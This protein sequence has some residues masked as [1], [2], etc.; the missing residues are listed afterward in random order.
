MKNILMAVDGSENS[1]R[2]VKEALD[3][4]KQGSAIKASVIYVAPNCYDL[5]PEPGICTWINH[6]EL[7]KE[8][9]ARAAQISEKVKALFEAEGLPLQFALERGV[10]SEA[11]C[12]TAEKGNFD[13]IVVGS[14]GFGDI[15]STIL[16]SVS[17]K[18]LYCS[19]CPVLV[20]K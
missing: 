17:H 16:G 14:R 12:S 11:I 7:E 18:V 1:L 19:Q 2:A 6:D 4:I 5:F 13:L 3:L 8:I 9:Q 10:P 20:V 15:K